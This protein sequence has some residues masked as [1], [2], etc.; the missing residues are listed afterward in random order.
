MVYRGKPSKACA[1]CRNRKTRCNAVRPMCA[2]CKRAGRVCSGYQ[3][4]EA[5]R[6]LD[7]TQTVAASMRR[8]ESRSGLTLPRQF[9]DQADTLS[10]AAS[11]VFYKEYCNPNAGF[12]DYDYD[13]VSP[14]RWHVRSDE[15]LASM[16]TSL[17]FIFIARM[18]NDRS[19][20]TAAARQYSRVLRLSAGLLTDI[21]SAKSD[22]MLATVWLLSLHES[23]ALGGFCNSPRRSAHLSGAAQLLILRGEE[24]FHSDIGRGMFMRLVG[25]IVSNCL[26]CETTVPC[27]LRDLMRRGWRYYHVE[28]QSE[29]AILEITSALCDLISVDH[30]TEML[31][32]EETYQSLISIDDL[33][34][35]WPS[36]LNSRY[37]FHRR[38]FR[39]PADLSHFDLYSCHVAVA[40]WNCY[41]KVRIITNQYVIRYAR[42]TAEVN[43][44]MKEETYLSEE[45]AIRIIAKMS[46]DLCYSIPF[47]LSRE[48]N[49]DQDPE[50]ETNQ[51][52]IYGGTSVFVALS[53]AAKEKRVSQEMHDWMISQLGRISRESGM[54]L[55]Q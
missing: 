13:F 34:A 54:G 52:T 23:I 3:E 51:M 4:P 35:A 16:V 8:R 30:G 15:L 46:E 37:V 18:S 29:L 10:S 47:L 9:P 2:Q 14:M 24:Q 11:C 21:E 20:I 36:T 6:V 50:C 25:R 7:Q 43:H 28:A 22:E 53:L 1:E 5:L 45:N 33:L 41:R 40:V 39:T 44:A 12:A 27:D 49:I 19:F 17:G 31:T 32:I 26:H 55:A 48:M 38:N 42:L